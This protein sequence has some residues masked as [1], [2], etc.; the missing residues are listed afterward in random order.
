[1][2][3]GSTH[4]VFQS[5]LATIDWICVIGFIAL[6]IGIGIYFSKRGT[7]S[8]G[9]YFAS[10]QGV[11][12]WILGTSMV[13]TTFAAD[14]P[15]AISGLVVKQG[16]WGNWFWW[17]QVPMFMIGVFFFS[18][19]WRRARI[20]TDTELIDLR[21]SGRPAKIL[22]GFRALYFAIPYNCLI[23]G[24]VIL[25]MTKILG[26]TF[27][28]DKTVAVALSI[29]I[30]M[31]YSSISGLWGV[32][33]TDFFQFILAMGMAIV[34]AVIA[35]NDVGGF[36][37]ILGE[38]K[39]IYGA[40]QYA[41]MTAIIPPLSN[42]NGFRI[43]LIYIL[44][45][46]WTVGNTD[47]GAYLAQRMI[48]AKNEK[49]SFLGYLWFNIAHFCLRPWPWIA[50]GLVAAVK[51]PNIIN[52]HTNAPDPEVGYIAV[53]LHFL[54]TR[55]GLLG[56][57]LTSFLAAFMST[58]STQINW[59]A[60]YLI[61]DFY[62]PFINKTASE[63]HYVVVSIL[64]T[65]GMAILGG[66]ISLAMDNIFMAWLLLSAINAGIGIVYIARWYWWRINAWSEMSAI[67]SILGVIVCLIV[68]DSFNFHSSLH[69]FGVC[70]FEFNINT[71]LAAETMLR[72]L[73]IGTII[74][75]VSALIYFGIRRSGRFAQNR[76]SSALIL[77]S[78]L[79]TIC[80]LLVL[81]VPEKVFPWTLLYTVPISLVIWLTV[82]ILTKPVEETKLIEFYRRVHPGGPGWRKIAEKISQDYSASSLFNW[83]NFKR[84]LLSIVAIYSALLG[85]GQF[86]VGRP[87]LGIGLFCLMGFCAAF[88]V[89]SLST[90]KWES[91]V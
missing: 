48:S 19:L 17:A 52:P 90:E 55:P 71:F 84:A 6:S 69:V 49:H 46:W 47:G 79:I 41:S 51:F 18:R 70:S 72:S 54:K 73:L 60:S 33:V 28:I 76:T 89:K 11:P 38:I 53:M 5:K 87:W 27:N 16:I 15:L 29:A 58:I 21:Y 62:K 7:R 20:L 83:V 61:N 50:V 23:M 36:A 82:T 66:L 56:L 68:F 2:I 44:L 75:T 78:A 63:R 40:E 57:M 45:L 3:P 81:T 80:V 43:F 67:L 26:L 8:V 25:A 86:F 12:W 1:M 42:L 13:A 37:S 34:L 39:T 30:T 31:L 4:F 77:I 91:A 88:V 9:D 65:I 24:W 35:V 74:L 85:V 64:T 22:R 14:T 59:G 10:G 32:M